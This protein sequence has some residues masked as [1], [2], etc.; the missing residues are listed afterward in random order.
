VKEL[1]I[2][3]AIRSGTTYLYKVLDEHPEIFLAKPIKPESKFF[4]KKKLNNKDV[5]EYKKKYFK[6]VSSNHYVGEKSTSYLESKTACK[7]I[8]KYFPDAR[9]I[10]ILRNPA[11]RAYSNYKFSIKNNIETLPFLEALDMENIRRKNKKFKTSVN[12]YLYFNRGKYYKYLKSYFN[13][14]S[15]KQIKV[16]IFEE[17]LNNKSQHKDLYGW[18]GVNENFLAPSFNK[19]INKSPIKNNNDYLS[20]YKKLSKRYK[21]LNQK[22]EN[23]I[24][25][26]ITVW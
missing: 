25:H 10:V 14:F 16:L 21:T 15:R 23:L 20:V 3:G 17:F 11:S 22:L 19:I 13:F 8:K 4:L 6:D 12:P 24:K 1:F 9:I 7:R 5:E 26:K 18:L 2:I